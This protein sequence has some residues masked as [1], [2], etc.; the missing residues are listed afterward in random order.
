MALVSGTALPLRV[1]QGTQAARGWLSNF[2]HYADTQWLLGGSSNPTGWRQQH[3]LVT[4]P[5]LAQ[6]VVP[7]H[8]L[9]ELSAIGEQW[10]TQICKSSAWYCTQ[11]ELHG[12]VPQSEAGVHGTTCRIHSQC[13]CA[14]VTPQ[15]HTYTAN[16]PLWRHTTP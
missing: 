2:A 9:Q 14:T 12:R 11:D 10:C 13:S 5:S 7:Q 1:A 8:I 4:R 15:L 16:A 6:S 3:Q